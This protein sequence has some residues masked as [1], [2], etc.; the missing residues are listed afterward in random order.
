MYKKKIW[1][2]ITLI[3][4][5]LLIIIISAS[6]IAFNYQSAINTALNI[7]TSKIVNPGDPDYPGEATGG[8][9]DTQ[10]FKS[11]FGEFTQENQT[12]MINATFEQAITEMKEGASLLYNKDKALPLNKA[13][14]YISCFG[15]ATITPLAAHMAAGTR[16]QSGYYAR[17][18]DAM[19]DEGFTVNETLYNILDTYSSPGI[20]KPRD[21]SL[22][23][24]TSG[25]ANVED[26]IDVYSA[27][28]KASWADKSNGIALYTIVRSGSEGTDMAMNDATNNGQSS[29]A[30]HDKEKAILNM[31]KD[32]KAAGRIKKIIILLNTGN[33]LEVH[34]LEDYNVDAC[35]FI[36]SIGS[37][38]ARG[39]ASILSGE[40]NPSGKLVD[41]YAVNSLSAP[42][43]VNSSDNTSKMT[44][45]DDVNTKLNEG[46]PSNAK[47]NEKVGY[48][49]FQAESIYIGYKYYETRYE[50]VILGRGNAS[51]SNGASNG[52]A[53]WK[54]ENEMSYPFGHGLS[55]TT[56]TQT[57]DSV[58]YNSDTDTYAVTVTVK[59]TGDVAG[60]SVVQVYAQT[61]Y[62]P[63]G[64]I[65]KAAIQLADFDKTKVL[66]KDAT[67]TLTINVDRYLLASYDHVTA[68]GY[69]L[70]EG[71]YYLAIG[72]NCHD[73]LNNILAAKGKAN[74][75]NYDGTAC[76]GVAAK[77]S[78]FR[79]GYD[80]GAYKMSSNNVL[81]TNRFDDCDINYW[82]KGAGKYL[83]RSD[84]QGTYPTSKTTIT[85][86]DAMMFVLK[87]DYYEKPADAPT[88]KEVIDTLGKDAGI[89]FV[90]MKDIEYDDTVTWTKFLKQMTLDD[91]LVVLDCY[92]GRNAVET[93]ALPATYIGDGCDGMMKGN[94]MNGNLYPFDYEDTTGK[95]GSGKVS[96]DAIR[97]TRYPS[98]TIL[99]MTFNKDLYERRGALMGEEGLWSYDTK[100]L[101]ELFG[102]GGNIHRTPFGGRALEYCTEDPNMTYLAT[103]PEVIAL[104]KKGVL[105]SIKHLAG[106]DQEYQ[107]HGV[108]S[109]FNEQAWR[110]G[111]LRAFEGAMRV[112]ECKASMQAFN[113]LGLIFASS[114]DALN[115][116]VVRGEWGFKGH[117]ETD[118]TDGVA[119]SSYGLMAHFATSLE[120][121]SDTW[122]LSTGAAAYYLKNQINDTNDGNL[123]NLVVNAAFHYFYAMS[124]S[125]AING[126]S[127]D[128]IVLKITP[129]WQTTLITVIVI[130]AVLLAGCV[131]LLVI[132]KLKERRQ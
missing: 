46:I 47:Y 28:A 99:T 77:A 87:G 58:K 111:S 78:K 23:T 121:G 94:P 34:W 66:E 12:K 115:N 38:G 80:A 18:N 123:V 106:N 108:S 16:P 33:P 52:A 17:I 89:K 130:A 30:L 57:L 113:R 40:T 25:R 72:D 131:V 31:L 102:I 70:T 126:L 96:K 29:L 83:S 51:G 73:A 39:V 114:S 69:V 98:K 45:F 50:D 127:S 48:V 20:S 124:R 41:T 21:T 15:R 84:W 53:S 125:N 54:Y 42:A 132:S 116:Q 4:T 103:I 2:G 61:P 120:A 129:W 55:Y 44:N 65:E 59:N 68:K 14:D 67:Q 110:E 35:M 10:Y 3:L 9:V 1:L 104:E 79:L 88:A 90:T 122:C 71:D 100:G 93:V 26:P 11:E 91:L 95:Y 19:K 101:V 74:L 92:N 62:D 7:S 107:R 75:I 43:C 24:V 56:F 22:G 82:V 97:A 6:T 37:Q 112:A 49:N 60:K 109:F 32:E 86:N 105:G 117:L 63:T 81:V 64:K 119:G 8:E 118:G 76:V 5:F 128:S 13:T 85:A 27:D 36:G